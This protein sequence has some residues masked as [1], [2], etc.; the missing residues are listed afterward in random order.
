[1]CLSSAAWEEQTRLH[2]V[3]LKERRRWIVLMCRWRVPFVAR[4]FGG[5]HRVQMCEL[6]PVEGADVG[7]LRVSSGVQ[8]RKG[9]GEADVESGVRGV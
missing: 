8:K 9:E 6:E 5:S 7:V 2:F 3:H 4:G 1:V